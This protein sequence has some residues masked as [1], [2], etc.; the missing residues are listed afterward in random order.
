MYITMPHRC[1][2]TNANPTQP[3]TSVII[4]VETKSTI[5]PTYGLHDPM[6]M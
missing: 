4:D 3:I 6:V 2:T 1:H 5:G